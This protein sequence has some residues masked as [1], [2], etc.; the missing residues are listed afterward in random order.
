MLLTYQECIEKYGSDYKLKK[1]L[2]SGNLFMKEKGVYS[3]LRYVSEIDV[4]MLKYTKTVCTGKSAFYYHSL[5]DVIPDHYYLATRRTDTRIKDPRIIQSF[6]KDDIFDAGITEIQYNNSTI[7]I[8]DKERML[9]ELLRFRFKMPM[10]YY[11]EIINN[12]RK[13]SFSLDFGLVEDYA[14]M[15][16]SCAKLMNMIQMEV[17]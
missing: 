1:E 14:A 11:K 15:F 7:R 17:L 16:K 4:I 12:Y 10:D 5:T 6:L 9:I 13:L 3:T 8:Y 2:G